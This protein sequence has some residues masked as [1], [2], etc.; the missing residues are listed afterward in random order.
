MSLR[1]QVEELFAKGGV[2]WEGASTEPS[3]AGAVHL[4]ALVGVALA[5]GFGC[6]GGGGVGLATELDFVAEEVE[7]A[8]VVHSSVGC[9]V[10]FQNIQ[11][12]RRRA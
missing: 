6:V 5:S 11:T 3:A 12:L 8:D 9:G 10:D 7:F 4:G 1:E 2:G